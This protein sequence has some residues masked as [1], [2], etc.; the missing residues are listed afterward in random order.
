MPFEVVDAN[1]RLVCAERQAF[2]CIQPDH[3]RTGQTGAAR[4]GDGIHIGES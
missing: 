4:H 1:Q 2:G 3:E